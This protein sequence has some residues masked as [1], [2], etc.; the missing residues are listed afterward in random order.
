[1][2]TSSDPGALARGTSRSP[3][4][5]SSIL[6]LG[7][8]LADSRDVDDERPIGP[9][10]ANPHDR[11]DEIRRRTHIAIAAKID[12]DADLLEVPRR[13]GINEYIVVGSQ[14]VLGAYPNAPDDLKVSM[15]AD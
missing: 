3:S 8:G 5:Q 2:L 10:W 15:E 12:A 1:M 4:L 6:A 13:N 7:N 9:R 14:S 11:L